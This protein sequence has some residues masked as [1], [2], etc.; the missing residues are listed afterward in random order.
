MGQHWFLLRAITN[1]R[2]ALG[3]R[4][5]EVGGGEEEEN[6]EHMHAGEVREGHDQTPISVCTITRRALACRPS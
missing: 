6:M 1:L 4:E 5:G 2:A 3:I